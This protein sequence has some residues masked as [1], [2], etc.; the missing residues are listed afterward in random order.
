MK[1]LLFLIVTLLALSGGEA[2]ETS[3]NRGIKKGE[4]VPPFFLQNKNGGWESS[5]K[6]FDNS[7]NILWFADI[8]K[9]EK[10]NT[11]AL[12]NLESDSVSVY[13]IDNN[14]YLSITNRKKMYKKLVPNFQVLLDF[15]DYVS[16]AYHVTNSSAWFLVDRHGVL[17]E[18]DYNNSLDF[19]LKSV[20]K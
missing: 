16:K 9:L 20:K 14:R 10:N 3:K 12:K 2:Q 1:Y 15:K 13:I 17:I 5:E 18:F 8:S 4:P 19:L 6:V 11:N 7:L